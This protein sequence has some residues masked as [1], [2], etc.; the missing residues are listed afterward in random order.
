MYLQR[1]VNKTAISNSQNVDTDSDFKMPEA[2][3]TERLGQNIS[4]DE[5]LGDN[6]DKQIIKLQVEIIHKEI[7]QDS[8]TETQ[9][10]SQHCD[11][12]RGGSPRK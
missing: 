7:Q 11:S 4:G 2:N 5:K 3:S 10:A 6:Y 1:V 12:Q 9:A 8:L